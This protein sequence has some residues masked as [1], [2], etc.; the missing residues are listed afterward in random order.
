MMDGWKGIGKQV[1]FID[2]LLI[3]AIDSI[4]GK[5]IAAGV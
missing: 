5:I 1:R 4:G 3:D 2:S